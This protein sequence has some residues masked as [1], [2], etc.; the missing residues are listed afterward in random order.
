MEVLHIPYSPKLYCRKHCGQI[1]VYKFNHNTAGPTVDIFACHNRETLKF[2]FRICEPIIKVKNLKP[3]FAQEINKDSTVGILLQPY[4][5]DPRNM[6]LRVNAAGAYYISFGEWYWN[7]ADC[8]FEDNRFIEILNCYKKLL[9]SNSPFWEISIKIHL[10]LLFEFINLKEWEYSPGAVM[11]GNFLKVNNL[12]K[13]DC[14]FGMWNEVKRNIFD[15]Y[16]SRTLGK[17]ILE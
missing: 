3:D 14:H 16:K 5:N 15:C 10:P 13:S 17:F 7:R 4:V 12:P 1:S 2:K 8:T 9:K 6:M 11:N